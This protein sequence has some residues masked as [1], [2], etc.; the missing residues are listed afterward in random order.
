[1]LAIVVLRL[2]IG[3]QLFYEGVWKLKTLRSP[4]PWTSAGYLKNSQGPMRATFR[5]MTGDP[6]ELDWLDAKKVTKRWKDWQSRF[7][8]H[9]GLSD[10]QSAKLNAIVNGS[11]AF[12]SDS[13]TPLVIPERIDLNDKNLTYNAGK[14]ERKPIVGFD[15]KNK[16][17]VIDGRR[18]IT[19]SEYGRYLKLLPQKDE[20]TGKFPDD[21]IQ[22]TF[23]EQ[24]H[25]VYLRATRLSYVEKLRAELNGNTDWVG[26]EKNVQVGEL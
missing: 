21:E 2:A 22:A 14:G 11:K 26:N 13:D 3:W 25:K 23:R 16:R 5:R 24:L 7:K 9:Y 20:E 4:T 1:M 12:Y 19:A 17:L 18:R 6:D 10:R 15:E 8:N